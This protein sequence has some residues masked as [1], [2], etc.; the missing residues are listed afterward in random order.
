MCAMYLLKILNG[1]GE[2]NDVSEIKLEFQKL[3]AALEKTA[4]GLSEN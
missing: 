2:S 4:A 1:C 3:S